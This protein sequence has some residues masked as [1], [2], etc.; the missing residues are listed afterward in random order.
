MSSADYFLKIDGVDGESTDDKHKKEIE[1]ES[2]SFG[3]TNAASFAS[4]GGGGTGKV[5]LQDIHFVKRIDK[6]SVKLFTA[7]CTGEHLKSAILIVRKQGKDQQEYL[8]ITLSDCLV[9]S[10]QNGGSAGAGVVPMDQLALAYSKIEYSYKEQ[11]PDGS[12]GGE[13]VGGWDLKTNKKV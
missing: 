9:S 12:L 8:K 3:G 13:V 7:M 5:A 1:I 2:F 11:K 4:G 6:A 10:Y